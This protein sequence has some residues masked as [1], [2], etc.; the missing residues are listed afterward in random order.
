MELY[1]S[2]ADTQIAGNIRVQAG[3]NYPD[4]RHGFLFKS[5]VEPILCL[6]TLQL[7]A[8]DVH[9][10]VQERLHNV[11]EAHLRAFD[12]SGWKV[13]I[14]FDVV[15]TTTPGWLACIPLAI[16]LR[17]PR[18]SKPLICAQSPANRKALNKK[19]STRNFVIFFVLFKNYQTNTKHSAVLLLL[20]MGSSI[21]QAAYIVRQKYRPLT[22]KHN[23]TL[24]CMQALYTPLLLMLFPFWTSCFS[25]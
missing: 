20:Q 7:H 25:K 4:A 16:S 6:E 24:Q 17:K 1:Q 14:I 15:R 10:T 22:R 2:R 19:S 13:E 5:A 23:S 9:M 8:R 11:A 21:Q 18:T 12:I 3:Q